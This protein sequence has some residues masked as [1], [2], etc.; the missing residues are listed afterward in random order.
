LV[1]YSFIFFQFLCLF[2]PPLLC[3]Q[4]IATAMQYLHAQGVLHGDLTPGNVLLAGSA[5]EQDGGTAVGRLEGDTRGW[6]ALVGGK[7]GFVRWCGDLGWWVLKW[8][9]GCW[10]L[11][12]W[13]LGWWLGGC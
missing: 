3:L 8:F 4:E 6:A 10:S 1:P 9:V 12:W 2:S 13:V 7:L 11:V 5:N